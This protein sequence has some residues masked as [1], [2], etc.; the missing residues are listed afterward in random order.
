LPLAAILSLRWPAREAIK[1]ELSRA[2]ESSVKFQA[3]PGVPQYLSFNDRDDDFPAQ[4]NLFFQQSAERY[5]NLKSLFVL[6]T[7]LAGHLIKSPEKSA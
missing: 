3:L 4:S 5:L 7:Y 2:F 1:D 6:G